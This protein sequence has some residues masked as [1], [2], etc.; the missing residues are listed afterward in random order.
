MSALLWYPIS[1]SVSSAFQNW[2][3][4][5]KLLSGQLR[6]FPMGQQHWSCVSL[7]PRDRFGLPSLAH[8][9]HCLW[10]EKSEMGDYPRSPSLPNQFVKQGCNTLSKFYG[11]P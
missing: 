8:H 7:E 3:D 1:G 9:I 11:T 5:E 10:D 2:G 6:P 4:R